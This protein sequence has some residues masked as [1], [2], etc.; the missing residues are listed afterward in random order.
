[1][2]GAFGHMIGAWLCGRLYERIT[3]TN[4]TRLM[5]AALL[6]GGIAP[7]GDFLIEWTTDNFQIHRTF[8]HSIFMVITAGIAVYF[9]L[10]IF[11]TKTKIYKPALV[12][13]LFSLG[14]TTH[15][16]LDL[17]TSE[18]GVQIMWPLSDKWITFNG[19]LNHHEGT[20]TYEQ[21]KWFVK[22][23]TIDMALGTAWI[24]Y[25]FWRK[26]LVFD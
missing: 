11:G 5:W 25:L 14:L 1:M 18:S 20:P 10:N 15:L 6:L 26:K 12:A 2:P 13:A 8:S 7:D 24:A 23:S 16:L 4:L 19:P 22:M 17:S 3:K 21:L 9:A